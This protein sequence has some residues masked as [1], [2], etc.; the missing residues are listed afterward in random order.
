MVNKAESVIGKK[1]NIELQK[2][3]YETDS[4][5]L[6]SSISTEVTAAVGKQD[7]DTGKD[8]SVGGEFSVLLTLTG[9]QVK[10]QRS[11]MKIQELLA[12]ITGL[13]STIMTI[14]LILNTPYATH[15]YYENITN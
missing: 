7:L 15:K 14:V 1:V 6:T 13:I 8:P 11:Y 10:Y 12:N 4:G 2:I 9:R 3:I 5:W